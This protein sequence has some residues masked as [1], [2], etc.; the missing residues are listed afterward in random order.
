MSVLDKLE[1]NDVFGYFEEI[2]N[3]PHPSHHTDEI[4][5]YLIAFA[6]ARSL[7]A[8]RDEANNVIIKKPA[9]AGY[10]NSAPV[11]LQGH[12]DM[13]CEKAPDCDK[14]MLNEGLDLA[15]DGDIVFAKGTT[16]GSDDGIAAAMMLALLDGNYEHPPLECVFTVDEEVG[17][18]GAEKLDVSPL[19]GKTMLNIDSEVEGVLTVGCAGG[20]NV[21]CTL[22]VLREDFSGFV[23]KVCVGGLKGGHS[24]IEIDKMRAN[25]NVL[26]GR[27]LDSIARETELR[28]VC[29]NGGLKD[30]AIARETK[31]EIV[32]SDITAAK[33]AIELMDAALKNEYSVTDSEVFV[34]AAEAEIAEKAMDEATSLSLV[35][36]LLCLP[37]GIQEM[38]A[39]IEGLV[40]TSLNFGILKTEEDTVFAQFCVRSSI[41]SQKEMLIRKIDLLVSSLGGKIE[42]SGNYPGWQYKP[43]SP[44]R[45]LMTDV[46]TEQYGYAPKIEAIHAGL[47]CGLFA[48]KIDGL[49]C[50]SFGPDLKEIHT[51]RETMSISSVQRVWRMVL[52]VLKRLK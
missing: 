46:F 45:D 7:Y 38:S 30:N 52:E 3:I 48:D 32:V 22:P 43:K 34:S 40:Q 42:I 2:C 25:S 51:C 8:I 50:V 15:V 47:E 28:I 14:D 16:L 12:V 4:S 17:M 9:S 19:K 37:N 36:M 29:V 20:A 24:G 10:F 18:L 6:K 41:A 49:D 1:P 35:T 44:L 5:E 23:L 21:T 33:R 31:A 13:V 27:V 39:D 26:M 11:I